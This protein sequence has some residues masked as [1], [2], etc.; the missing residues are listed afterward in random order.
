MKYDLANR[1]TPNVLGRL[2]KG[3]N[4][5]DRD[6]KIFS[7][8]RLQG[9]EALATG[10]CASTW[11]RRTRNPELRIWLICVVNAKIIVTI[12]AA[13]KRQHRKAEHFQ[14]KSKRHLLFVRFL[15]SS[16]SDCAIELYETNAATVPSKPC[17]SSIRNRNFRGVMI[18][19]IV[20]LIF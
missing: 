16:S 9:W 5:V 14:L 19:T 10:S 6:F 12:H 20:L 3:R 7:L 8:S 1:T 11:V 18:P 4:N 13:I 17:A 2:A 15:S